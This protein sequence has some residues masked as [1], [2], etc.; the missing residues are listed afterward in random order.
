MIHWKIYLLKR[1]D[2]TVKKTAL[3]SLTNNQL[4]SKGNE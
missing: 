3:N 2:G 1:K 4:N